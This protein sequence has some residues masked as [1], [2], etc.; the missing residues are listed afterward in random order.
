MNRLPTIR[1]RQA[2]HAFKQA[3]F[4]EVG[5]TGSHLHLWHAEQKIRLIIPIHSGDLKRGLMKQLIRQAG[6]TEKEFRSFL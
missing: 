2:V 6:L 3:G 5:Q 1:A 4:S